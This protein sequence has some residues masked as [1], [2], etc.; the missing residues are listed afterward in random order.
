MDHPR[1]HSQSTE[2]SLHCSMLSFRLKGRRTPPGQHCQSTEWSLHCSMLSFRLKGR[3][4]P[5]GQHCRAQSDLFTVQCCSF[6]LK[7]RLTSPSQHCQ[8]TELSLHCSM[9]SFRLKGRLI[10]CKTLSEHRVISSLFNVV[11]DTQRQMDPTQSTQFRA[12][13]DLFTVQMSPWSFREQRLKGRLD[14]PPMC[15]TLSEH[16]VISSLFNVVIQTQ[17]QVDPQSTLS[18]HRVISSLFNVIIETQRQIDL[19]QSTLSEHRVISSLFNVIMRLK[20]RWTAPSQHCQSTELSLHCS[21]LQMRLKDRW[22]PQN[23]VRAQSDLFTVQCCHSDSKDRPPQMSTVWSPWDSKAESHVSEH[24]VISSLFNVVI[25]RQRSSHIVRQTV[26]WIFRPPMD[27][28]CAKHCQSTEWSLHCSM[29]SLQTLKAIA[30]QSTELSLHCSPWT[31][32]NT[33]RAQSDLFTVQCCHWD[34]IADG[35]PPV[36]PLSEHRVISS[37]F[38]VVIQTQ[39]QMDPLQSNTVRAQMWSLHCSMLSFRLKGR[40]TPPKSTLSEHRVISSLFNVVIETQ[41]Q[42]DLNSVQS[43]EISSLS[44]VRPQMD[45]KSTWSELISSLFNVVIET[46]AEADRTR[47]TAMCQW[48]SKQIQSTQS[49]HRVIS[50]LFNVVI[51][52]QRQMETPWST[53]SEHRVISSLFNVVIQTQDIT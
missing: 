46:Q 50:S 12:Q 22:T 13:S 52:T 19:P 2:W 31:P 4:T 11:I 45:P 43:S 35:P 6:R 21:M 24:R 25:Q 49:E 29:L 16:R 42:M 14:G 17:R 48:D 3:W 15:K 7:G 26:Q 20:G 9:L 39:R 53:L 47:F 37:L 32:F 34:S 40:W 30:D 36:K 44:A 23:S 1:Q 51:E 33:V 5:P 41:R 18:E 28:L 8:N 27:P 10:T 38:N